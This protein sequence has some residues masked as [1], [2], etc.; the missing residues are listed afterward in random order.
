MFQPVLKG[1]HRAYMVSLRGRWRQFQRAANKPRKAQEAR[2]RS[3]LSVRRDTAFAR[4]HQLDGVDSF[5]AF[6]DRVPIRN[7]QDMAPWIERIANGEKRVLTRAPVRLMERSRGAAGE[8]KLVPYTDALFSEF[9]A[10]TGPWLRELSVGCP[11]LMGTRSYWG[12]TPLPHKRER[13]PGGIPIGMNDDREYFSPLARFALRRTRAVRSR[14]RRVADPSAWRQQTIKELLDCGDLGMISVWHPTFLIAIME[15]LAQN[16]EAILNEIKPARR[17]AILSSLDEAG[18][19]VGEAVWPRL[20]LLSCYGEGPSAELIPNLRAWFPK[21]HIQ[22]KGLIATEGIVSFP[23][24]GGTGNVLA[25]TSHFLEFQDLEAPNARPCLADELRL[26]GTYSPIITTAGGLT[27]YHLE[28]AVRCVGFH[29]STPCIEFLGR[30]DMTANLAGEK[31]SE[32]VVRR[33]I[34]IAHWETNIEPRFVLCTPV[35]SP[36]A[37]YRLFLERKGSEGD[38]TNFQ[39][40]LERQL[41]ESDGYRSARKHGLLAELELIEVKGGWDTFQRVRRREGLAV[42]DR[43]DQAYLDLHPIW[44]HAFQKGQSTTRAEIS[45]DL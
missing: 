4:E 11:E 32:A 30:L 22:P 16:L 29:G 18:D 38:L 13:T 24:W 45:S 42:P 40:C 5:A 8:V 9:A 10:A 3:L 27:R 19:L 36:K 17:A 33:A 26:G 35:N 7:Y 43:Q 31:L 21:A 37:R 25:V 34:E 1:V 6:Q 23:L 14:V 41:Q 12:M 28:D 15:E 2:L 39:F 20:R 44:E